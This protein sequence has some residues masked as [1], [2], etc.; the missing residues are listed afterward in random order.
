M[1]EVDIRFAQHPFWDFSLAVYGHEGVAAACLDLQ[2]RVGLDV[3]L[4]LFCLWSGLERGVAFDREGFAPVVIAADAWNESVVQPIRAARR[5]L[6]QGSAYL[7]DD[8]TE[9]LRRQVLEAEIG[10]EHGEQLIIAAAAEAVLAKARQGTVAEA[11]AANLAVYADA[12]GFRFSNADRLPLA[13]IL[14]ARLHAMGTE[15]VLQTLLACD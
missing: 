6:K 2:D 9:G 14:S 15:D 7:R 10:C 3:N 5:R 12:A 8:I 11:V 13:R 4:L 1:A